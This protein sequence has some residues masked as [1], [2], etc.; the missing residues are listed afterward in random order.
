MALPG[1]R[2]NRVGFFAIGWHVSGVV[3]PCGF[4]GNL[5]FNGGLWAVFHHTIGFKS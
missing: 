1:V 5:R 2:A 3:P 4:P